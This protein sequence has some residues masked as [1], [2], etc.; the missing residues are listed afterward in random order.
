MTVQA[1]VLIGCSR[2]PSEVVKEVRKIQGVRAAHAL[3]GALEAI[4]F[5][6]AEDLK[7]LDRVIAEMYQVEG[8]RN[9]DTRI[10]R[11]D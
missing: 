10:V 8:L 3:Y 5:V 2:D 6:E 7:D 4:A 1:Y 11:P 9:T